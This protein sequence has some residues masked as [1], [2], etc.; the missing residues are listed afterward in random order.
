MGTFKEWLMTEAFQIS[1]R[2][3]HE[4][5]R[6]M[7][8]LK[9]NYGINARPGTDITKGDAGVQTNDPQRLI[10]IFIWALNN[11][12]AIEKD[13]IGKELPLNPKEIDAG[14]Y[15]NVIVPVL[16]QLIHIVDSVAYNFQQVGFKHDTTEKLAQMLQKYKGNI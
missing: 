11:L 6:W 13:I 3:F 8:A 9:M 1:R 14:N 2:D 16:K 15:D 10:R 7:L 5:T 12:R 4:I